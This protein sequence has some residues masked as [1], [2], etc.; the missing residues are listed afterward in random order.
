M[1]RIQS[2]VGVLSGFPIQDTVDKLLV[3]AGR[4]RDLLL[5]RTEHLKSEQ[6]AVGQLTSLV[7]GVQFVIER[8][9]QAA[10]FNAKT[11]TSDDRDLLSANVT[12]SGDPV[13]GSYQ[14]TP[15]QQAHAHQLISSRFDSLD[16]LVGEGS[17]S[18][19]FG[20][21][22]DRGISL[23]ELNA[24]SGIRRGQIRITDRS[25]TSAVID[26][27]FVQTVDDV[28][29]TI[30]SN[31]LVNV[32]AVTEGDALRLVDNTG[33]TVS[34]L[35]VTEVAG[36]TTAASLGLGAIDV[37]ASAATGQDVLTLHDA[38]R[39]ASLNDGSGINIRT[40]LPDLQITFSDGSP[41]LD[42]AFGEAT[43]LGGV[44]QAINE[45][46]PARLGAQISTDGDRIEL[47][48][49]TSGAGTF[50][51]SSPVGGTAAENLGL[52]GSDVGGVIT[53]RRLQA[54]LNTVLLSNLVGGKGLD[55]LDVVQLTDRAGGPAVDV[56]LSSA[57]T[58]Q[59]VVDQI[60]DAGTG[61]VAR[62]ND[63]HSGILL[64]DTTGGA[65]N[66][67]VANG[68]ATNTAD[69]LGIAVDGAQNTVDSG[70]LNLQVVSRNT[71]LASLNGG[72]G[73][74][75][76]SFVITDS[77]GERDAVQLNQA[78]E[79]I[80][81][82]GGVIDAINALDVGVLARI[83]DRGD[84]ILLT[85]TAGGAE[86]LNVREVGPGTA[87]AD[88]HLVGEAVEVDVDGV[89]TQTIDGS[90]T[91]TIQ[92]TAEDTVQDLIDKI[93]D[94]GA[95]AR[96]SSFFDGRRHRLLLS[97]ENTGR[98]NEL[99]IE[100]SGVG[101]GFQDLI[102]SRDAVLVFGSPGNA[103]LELLVSSP[104]NTFRGVIDGVAVTVNGT[105]DQPVTINVQASDDSLTNALS[106]FVEAFNLL[107]EELEKLTFYDEVEK[108]TGI[109]FGSNVALSVETGFADLVGARIFGVGT[110]QSLV[111]LGLSLNGTGKLTFDPKRLHDKFAKDSDAIEEF[112][113]TD[114]KDLGKFG[115]VAKFNR[116][117]NQL[118]TEGNSLLA[119]R[120]ETLQRKIEVNEKRIIFFNERLDRE[121]TR[122]LTTFLLME[123]AIGQMQNNLSALSA[124]Q[125]LPPLI[126]Q[127]DR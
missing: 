79:E 16:D 102:K 58:L 37:A 71:T 69:R 31:M 12:G 18:F 87:A 45:A 73:V 80:T 35:L 22:V 33:Q 122:L 120:S 97:G 26:L 50:S 20:G 111:E 59:D 106:D 39:L 110:I 54:G 91:Q 125:P 76:R 103:T 46:D 98:A 2:A 62:V 15:V 108:T 72:S 24:G 127:S 96:A 6:L 11:A 100:T 124:L 112:F 25:G 74:A 101:V 64:M 90:T 42:I 113:T 81:T 123:R 49:L 30:N 34:N 92:L 40:S 75:P 29:D 28:L 4:P 21:F 77:T 36:G 47:L 121:R 93:N 7:L 107:R 5:A 57:E 86:T 44:L 8:L 117:I 10:I 67:I 66:L 114:D 38:T 116:L 55:G 99:Q 68:D 95:G 27:R 60:N 53:S 41:T 19:R 63:A 3:V 104:E 48:D 17:L 78:G 115:A 85:D 126:V 70:P 52:T 23:D 83:N 89:P 84:G 43:T 51:A 65:G 56:D 14:F 94:S 109:L 88:L 32:T 61:I 13:V 9:G 82:L 1:G 118:V 119:N 105:S